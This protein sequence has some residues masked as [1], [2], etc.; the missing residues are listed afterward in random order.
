MNILVT[1]G[2]GYIGSH[3]VRLLIKKRYNVVVFDNLKKGHKEAVNEKAFFVEGDLKHKEEIDRVI[4]EN[5]ISAVMH[6]ASHIIIPESIKNPEKYFRNIPNWLNLMNSMKDNDVK[7]II[8]SSSAAVYGDPK[9]I[10][11][12]E[13]DPIMP[14]NPYGEIKVI[15][16]KILK[17]YDAAYNIKYVSM[18]YFN[19]AGADPSGEMGE[20][21]R[22]E[23]HLIPI[24]LCSILNNESVKVFGTDYKTKDG[25][26]IRDYV[27][28][29]DIAEAH[30]LALE[31][32]YKTGKSKIY[33][34]GCKE[35]YSVREVI[36]ICEEITN[37]KIKVIEAGRREGDPAILVADS[38]KIRKELNWNPKYD[39][40]DIIRTAWEWHKNHPKG[41]SK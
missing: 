38:D 11:I 17:W 3:V 34:I 5:K 29:N 26:C 1:G 28:V 13:N 7:N 2:A 12:K 33:N 6:F 15:F 14:K 23:T 37:R 27:H 19:A 36:K 4:K 32:L 35:G 24:V 18:R 10:P 22:P 25:T 9:R 8:F 21:H 16:E 39:L 30:I 40:K 20:D 41:Y 31:H